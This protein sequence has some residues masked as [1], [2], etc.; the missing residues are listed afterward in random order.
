MSE[1]AQAMLLRLDRAVCH[2]LARWARD[3]MRSV[4]AQVVFLLLRALSE[5]GRLPDQGRADDEGAA[6]SAGSDDG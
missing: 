2:A 6:G 1:M 5:S 3:E 4:N